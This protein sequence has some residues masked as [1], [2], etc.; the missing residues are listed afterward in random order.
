[1]STPAEPRFRDIREFRDLN[2]RMTASIL[3]A[4]ATDYEEG[5]YVRRVVEIR[6][7]RTGAVHPV[8]LAVVTRFGGNYLVSPRAD[9]N[10]VRNL[11]GSPLCVVRA[12]D[13]SETKYAV[14]VIDQ[15]RAV[16]VV[17]TYLRLMTSPWTVAQ[18][19][20][21]AD[22]TPDEVANAADQVAVFELTEPQ[23]PS[24][25]RFGPP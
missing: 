25:S 4:P 13:T 16:D 14:R 3:A 21:A 19:P 12:R 2:A 23:H 20:F 9:R 15:A 7:R 6:G 22:A 5:G 24:V 18:F 11:A 10:W 8:P 1:M 17:C